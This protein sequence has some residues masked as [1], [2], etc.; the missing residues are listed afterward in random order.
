MNAQMHP[1]N[2]YSRHPEKEE[3]LAYSILSPSSERLSVG[4]APLQ[5]FSV[6]YLHTCAF[7]NTEFSLACEYFQYK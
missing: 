1:F 6:C 2:K 5:N 3:N 7:I 4:Y